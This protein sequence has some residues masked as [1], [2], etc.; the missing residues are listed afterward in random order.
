MVG[1]LDLTMEIEK[2]SLKVGKKVHYWVEMLVQATVVMM[3]QLKV[4]LTVDM[5]GER[6]DN[7]QVEWLVF[8]W[9][10]TKVGKKV[11]KRADWM[12][13]LKE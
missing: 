3:V 5:R 8:W 2:G 4:A 12:V 11:D 1:D 13:F 6:L 7:K 10:C 9:V